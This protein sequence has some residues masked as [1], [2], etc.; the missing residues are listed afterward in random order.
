MSGW[1]LDGVLGFWVSGGVEVVWRVCGG[2]LEGVWK[3]SGWYF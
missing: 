2:C 1:C 3:V